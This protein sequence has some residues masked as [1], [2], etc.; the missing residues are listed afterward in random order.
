[1]IYIATPV[2]CRAL[3]LHQRESKTAM[4]GARENGKASSSLSR[5]RRHEV[6]K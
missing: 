4:P 5:Q 3:K 6:N 1:M 2:S